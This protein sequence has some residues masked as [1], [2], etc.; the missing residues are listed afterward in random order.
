MDVEDA[1]VVERPILPV[2]IGIRIPDRHGEIDTDDGN[3][4]VETYAEAGIHGNLPIKAIKTEHTSWKQLVGMVVPNVAGIDE[5]SAVE[6]SLNGETVLCV[7]LQLDV[8]DPLNVDS[9]ILSMI[10]SR[11][12]TPVV[13]ASHPH[14]TSRI[15]TPF[16]R[17]VIG[18]AVR[19]ADTNK[20]PENQQ[21]VL[22]NLVV[23]PK[24]NITT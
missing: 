19:H 18:I 12:Q 5:H 9:L 23:L 13:P 11:T 22:S 7:Q 21:G 17:H 1:H 16:K 2:R 24:V 20:L 8:T 4:H 3:L 14:R 6:A 15:K 10:G